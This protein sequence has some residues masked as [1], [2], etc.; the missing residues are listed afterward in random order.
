MKKGKIILLSAVALVGIMALF[1]MIWL[2]SGSGTAGAP[3]TSAASDGTDDQPAADTATPSSDLPL[4]NWGDSAGGRS[5]YT[6]E[7]VAEGR[8][9][10]APILNSLA[11][12]F[13]GDPRCFMYGQRVEPDG[14]LGDL[15]RSFAVQPGEVYR[16]YMYVQND[17]LGTVANGTRAAISVPLISTEK[18]CELVGIIQTDDAVPAEVWST[19]VLSAEEDFRLGYVYGSATLFNSAYPDGLFLDDALVTKASS[20]SGVPIGYER[21]NGV[22]PGGEGYRA[23]V[24][25]MV[26]IVGASEADDLAEA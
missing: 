20:E 7:D 23:I 8:L 15:D 1:A 22:L 18:S 2:I 17:N 11:N 12:D 14:T 16:V 5:A 25:I 24:S 10:E 9:G 13:I 4:A 19:F 6:Q 26:E 3:N 21:M